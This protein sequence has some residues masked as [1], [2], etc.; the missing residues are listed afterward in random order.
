MQNELKAVVWAKEL[1][2]TAVEQIYLENK[3]D[4]DEI[5]LGIIKIPASEKGICVR[6]LSAINR[7]RSKFSEI[8]NKNPTA[9]IKTNK[10]WDLV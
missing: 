4:F 10:D 9:T 7:E 2:N 5:K 3:E 1:W 6:N 8:A